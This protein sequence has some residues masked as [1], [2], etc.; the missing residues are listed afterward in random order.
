MKIR[1]VWREAFPQPNIDEIRHLHRLSVWTKP[2][3]MQRFP[4]KVSL[5]LILKIEHLDIFDPLEIWLGP[6]GTQV[7]MT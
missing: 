2:F 1:S 5:Y 3:L 6:P 7:A 4:A